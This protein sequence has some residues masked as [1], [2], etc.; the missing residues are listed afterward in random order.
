LKTRRYSGAASAKPLNAPYYGAWAVDAFS[1]NGVERPPLFTDSS[2]WKLLVFD[3]GVP[4]PKPS[5]VIHFAPGTRRL[6]SV[7]FDAGKKSVSLIRP[8]LL[9]GGSISP[10]QQSLRKI[11]P[12]VGTFVVN[13]EDHDRLVLEGDFEGQRVRA[14]LHRVAPDPITHKWRFRVF[15][16]DVFFGDDVI[17]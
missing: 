10:E 5:L 3:W 12:T 7:N 8:N 9:P 11:S 16:D 17:I 2:R 14:L 6:F 15:C 13:D 4:Y 1:V